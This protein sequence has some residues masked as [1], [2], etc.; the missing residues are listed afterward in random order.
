MGK[1][2]RRCAAVLGAAIAA[3]LGCGDVATVTSC[4]PAA[5]LTPIC[6]FTNPEDLAALPGGASS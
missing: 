3:L 2:A 4:N 5:G 6:C 1:N